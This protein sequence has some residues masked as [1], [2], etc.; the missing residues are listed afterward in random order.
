MFVNIPGE[1]TFTPPNEMRIEFE[2]FR[3]KI[4]IVVMTTEKIRY[5]LNSQ[6]Q[7][8]EWLTKTI[9]EGEGERLLQLYQAE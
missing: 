6:Q 7:Y 2:N 4:V 1:V 8:D 3:T 9:S 5:Y